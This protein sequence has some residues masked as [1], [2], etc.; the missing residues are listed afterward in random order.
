MRWFRWTKCQVLFE[1]PR[2]PTRAEA[3]LSH[4]KYSTIG[5]SLDSAAAR[6]HKPVKSVVHVAHVGPTCRLC[7]ALTG[8]FR[9]LFFWDHRPLWRWREHSIFTLHD[10]RYSCAIII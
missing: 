8:G 6:K 1:P 9:R 2:D 4:Y 7:T 5:Y 10:P 3:W